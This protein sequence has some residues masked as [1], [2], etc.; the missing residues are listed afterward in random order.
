[1]KKAKSVIVSCAITGSIHTP[2]MSPALPFAPKDIAEQAIDAIA[3]GAAIVHLHARDPETAYPSPNPAI[4]REFVSVIKGRTDAV[5]NITTGGSSRMQLNQRIAAAKD[6]QPELATCNMGSMN[7]AFSAAARG[8]DHWRYAWEKDFVLGSDDV[9]FSNTFQQIERIMRE[10]GENG[11]RF[12]FECYDVGH[13]YTLAHFVER[14][15]VQPPFLVQ[16]IFGVQGGIGP[17]HLNLTHMATIADRLFGDDY[18]FSAFAAGRHQMPFITHAA[19]L[20]GHV[21]VGLEDS[22]YIARGELAESNAQQVEKAAQIVVQIGRRLASPADAREM[23]RLK[24]KE[25]VAF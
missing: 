7:F 4:F 2:S 18:Y 8:I 25:N 23:L 24:G 3:A 21:R 5:I 1:M 6:L 11:T 15:L 22:L 14:K 17:D 20:G 10:L 13:L 9:I 19:L 16:C 12:E